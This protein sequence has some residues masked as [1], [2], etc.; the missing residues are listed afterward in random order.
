[1]NMKRIWKRLS[2]REK[3]LVIASLGVWFLVMGRYFFIVPYLQHRE[4]VKSQLEIQP[5]LLEKNLRF[6]NQK[7]ELEAG[8]EKARAELKGLE[9]AL[10][11]GAT[12]SISASSLQEIV[13]ALAAKEGTQVIT[14]RVLNPE[15]M[16]S[17]TKIPIQLEVGAQI[18]QLANFIKGI[19]S[20]EKI[21]IVNELNI[22]S[23]FTPAAA[24]RPPGV[25]QVPVQT[26]RASLIVSGFARNQ[27]ASPKKTESPPPNAAT[28]QDK[29]P[30]KGEA[31]P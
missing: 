16:G 8:L 28:K 2:K 12:S 4:S 22:R 15:V 20:A 7:A 26:L 29:A 23:L 17:F 19:G 25:G 21:L 30:A 3:R 27:T 14:T 11:S 10:L 1:M 31:R 5:Q 9:S 24:V 13:E 6:I 18:D